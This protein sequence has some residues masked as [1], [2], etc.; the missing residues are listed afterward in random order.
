M[1]GILLQSD[2]PTFASPFFGSVSP[3]PDHLS[4]TVT[5]LTPGVSYSLQRSGN[6]NSNS[7]QTLQSFSPMGFSTNLMDNPSS[8]QNSTFYRIRSN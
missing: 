4:L 1:D 6:L 5:N 3:F 7:W 2:Q 8:N